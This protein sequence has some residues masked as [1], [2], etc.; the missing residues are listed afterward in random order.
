MYAERMADFR[1]EM[2]GWLAAGRIE[3]PE[4]VFEGL[5]QAPEALIAQLRGESL[6]K[7]LVELN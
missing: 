3:Y 4:T 7:V 2:R 5:E 1:R 6:G